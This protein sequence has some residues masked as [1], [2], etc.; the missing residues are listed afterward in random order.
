MVTI[1]PGSGPVKGATLENAINNI[2]KYVAD[3]G[4]YG[5]TVMRSPQ[6][7]RGGRFGFLLCKNNMSHEILMP[8]LTLA[9][10]RFMGEENQSPFNFPRI[11]VNGSSWLWC[12]GMLSENDYEESA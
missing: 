10:V 7:D 11:Y 12:F 1:N 2:V 3:C 8:G 5:I 6:E 4:L 9:R